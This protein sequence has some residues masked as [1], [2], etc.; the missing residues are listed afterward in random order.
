MREA[1]GG[2][3]LAALKSL[4][5]QGEDQALNLAGGQLSAP[6][7]V[8]IRM[9]FPDHYLRITKTD[10]IEQRAGFSADVLLNVMKPLRPDVQA[11]P[12]SWGPDQITT[13]RRNFAR[14][15]VG[16]LGRTDVLPGM[17]VTAAGANALQFDAPD[18][19]KVTVELDPATHLPLRLRYQASVRLPFPSGQ[20]IM[21]LPPAVDAEVTVAFSDRRRVGSLLLAHH[22]TTTAKGL[23]FDEL[24]FDTVRV[25]PGLRPDDFKK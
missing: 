20:P 16:L 6:T 11:G 2:A 23:T 19:F 4:T 21:G 14:L 8:E 22:L 25:D 15:A 7:S 17:Q 9:L 18:G 3:R 10:A 13:E 1:I 24:R 5:F 12:G